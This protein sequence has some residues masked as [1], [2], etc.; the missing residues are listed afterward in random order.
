MRT[1]LRATWG[2]IMFGTNKCCKVDILPEKDK[3]QEGGKDKL[4]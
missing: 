1:L 3:G 4:D 2:G